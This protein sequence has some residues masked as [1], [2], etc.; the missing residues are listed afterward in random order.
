MGLQLR[1]RL[2]SA[3]LGLARGLQTFFYELRLG[4]EGLQ[5]YF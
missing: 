5:L 1:L 2:G 3:A 4:L